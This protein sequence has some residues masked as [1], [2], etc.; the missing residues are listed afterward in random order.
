MRVFVI[1]FKI[2]MFTLYCCDILFGRLMPTVLTL[3]MT[4]MIVSTRVSSTPT[5][6]LSDAEMYRIKNNVI[7]LREL[8]KICLKILINKST[9]QKKK[10]YIDVNQSRRLRINSNI[11]NIIFGSF[12]LDRSLPIRCFLF[13]NTQEFYD[14]YQILTL[15]ILYCAF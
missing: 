7:Q 10:N 12:R 13:Q 9:F 11:N 8:K 3:I 1:Y 15:L 14:I 6:N 5:L 4:T 2:T